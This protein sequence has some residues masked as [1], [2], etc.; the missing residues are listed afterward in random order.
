MRTSIV[1]L[2]LAALGSEGAL[3][4]ERSASAGVGLKESVSGKTVYIQTPIGEEV[5]IRYQ[6]NGTMVGG[7]SVQLAALAGESVARDKGRWWVSNEQ[8]CQ[9]WSS[10]SEGRA[11]C[12]R[13]RISGNHVQ[14]SRNDGKTGT[15]R[16]SN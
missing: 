7:S 11:L 3:A 12:Y 4:A 2:A 13:L 6:P 16:L 1:I 14:W 10:W 5:A 8:L 15:A 9:K